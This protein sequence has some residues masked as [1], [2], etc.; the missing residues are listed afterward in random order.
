MTAPK[1]FWLIIEGDFEPEFC[2]SQTEAVKAIGAWGQEARILRV[3]PE[4]GVCED[5]TKE[6]AWA[7][8]HYGSMVDDEPAEA[9]VQYIGD[10]VKERRN[11]AEDAD[12]R[13]AKADAQYD[14]RND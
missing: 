1:T 3:S 5:E 12:G 11:A 7:W 9:F 6:L 14:A 13:W 8:L 2:T 4:A 10:A